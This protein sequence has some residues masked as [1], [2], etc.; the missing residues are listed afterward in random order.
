MKKYLILLFFFGLTSTVFSQQQESLTLDSAIN[1]Y[2]SLIK[3]DKNSPFGTYAMASV[4]FERKNYKTAI[5]YCDLNLKKPNEYASKA[6]LIKGISLDQLNRPGDAVANFEKAIKIYPQDHLLWYNL[7]FSSYKQ[8]YFEKALSATNKS[9]T[10]AP[11]FVDSYKLHACILYENKNNKNLIYSLLHSLLMV[12]AKQESDLILHFM[13]NITEKKYNDIEVPYFE[14]R[15]EMS[16][17]NEILQFYSSKNKN[18][19]IRNIGKELPNSLLL[20]DFNVESNSP[21]KNFYT[22]LKNEKLEE[23]YI[24][25]CLRFSDI[26]YVSGWIKTNK[27]ELKRFANF[28]EKNL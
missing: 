23:A 21:L 15:Y 7:A 5:E 28:L 19:E 1:Y 25:Y 8:Q 18:Q 26:E 6:Y 13:N 9:M 27:E 4:H 20:L 10:L 12:T 17:V 16:D 14:K 24:N 11:L 2:Q 3:K 22:N